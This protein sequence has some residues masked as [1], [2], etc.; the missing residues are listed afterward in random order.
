MDEM[1][2]QGD[3]NSRILTLHGKQVMLDKELKKALYE[4]IASSEIAEDKVIGFL[5]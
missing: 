3:I 4:L 2:I 1:I 5:K